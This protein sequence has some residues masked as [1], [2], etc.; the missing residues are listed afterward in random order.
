VNGVIPALEWVSE[1]R[2]VAWAASRYTADLTLREDSCER[3]RLLKAP[4]G[5]HS[6]EALGPRS[7]Y[8]DSAM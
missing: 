7:R 8:V 3:E 1:T 2:E 6:F 5:R 4:V